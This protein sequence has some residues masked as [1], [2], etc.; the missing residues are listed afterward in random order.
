MKS[1][2]TGLYRCSC[3]HPYKR[4]TTSV[5][6]TRNSPSTRLS[7]NNS[8]GVSNNSSSPLH[9]DFGLFGI[10]FCPVNTD[11]SA[12]VFLF[13]WCYGGCIFT[14]TCVWC[15]L[16]T[17][18][19]GPGF[20]APSPVFWQNSVADC[21]YVCHSGRPN[22]YC[23]GVNYCPHQW[24]SCCLPQHHQVMCLT[25]HMAHR[26]TP[27]RGT[28]S[29]GLTQLTEIISFHSHLCVLATR[30]SQSP[31]VSFVMPFFSCS[32]PACRYCFLSP[33][34]LHTRHQPV[35]STRSNFKFKMNISI[36]FIYGVLEKKREMSWIADR[37]I[38]D[39]ITTYLG[40]IISSSVFFLSL[41]FILNPWQWNTEL[42]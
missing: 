31:A 38:A 6:E 21:P 35:N 15:P 32:R 5:S 39:W 19:R 23:P 14:A 13:P 9:M 24:P 34:G 17:D 18:G 12:F 30:K 28:M 2:L 7:S 4:T 42:K 33:I 8:L 11:V 27:F 16:W 40:I 36:L 1:C 29:C 10:S 3:D 26:H 37:L 20:A 41:Q 25:I 22:L